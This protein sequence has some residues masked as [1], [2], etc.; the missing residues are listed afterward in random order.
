VGRSG[1]WIIRLGDGTDESH[2]RIQRALDT[3]W[4]Y[5]GELFEPTE[6]ERTLV[7]RGAA[8]DVAALREPWMAHVTDVLTEATL[9]VPPLGGIQHGG[10]QGRHTE[11]LGYLLAE[12][13]FLQRAYPGCSW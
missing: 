12:M 10:K 6:A 3:L 7:E 13:Q 9:R 2:G 1:E 8:T 11:H 5:T 4:P